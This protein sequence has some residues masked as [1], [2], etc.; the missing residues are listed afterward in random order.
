MDEILRVGLIPLGFF[1]RLI[2][3]VLDA[4]IPAIKGGINSAIGLDHLI[5]GECSVNPTIR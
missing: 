5:I 3:R 4:G 1:N 2:Q